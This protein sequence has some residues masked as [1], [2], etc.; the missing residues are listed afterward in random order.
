MKRFNVLIKFF[1]LSQYFW[2]QNSFGGATNFSG[3]RRFFLFSKFKNGISLVSLFN[4]I[5]AY[6][7]YNISSDSIGCRINRHYAVGGKPIGRL[8]YFGFRINRTAKSIFNQFQDWFTF[9]AY[10]NAFRIR[11][12]MNVWSVS[13]SPCRFF[14]AYIG[15]AVNYSSNISVY[16]GGIHV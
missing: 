3:F 7:F 14:D 10:L 13:H 9:H 5:W 6:C 11:R 4:Q 8:I 1:T 16:F 2:F 12:A 15:F